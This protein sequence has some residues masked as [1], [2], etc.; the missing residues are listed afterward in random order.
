MS[1]WSWRTSLFKSTVSGSVGEGM[2]VLVGG[3]M[4]GCW[5]FGKADA[6]GKGM[7]DGAW[8]DGRGARDIGKTVHGVRDMALGTEGASRNW[9][10]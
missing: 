4:G 7:A 5:K 10:S 1:R 2:D 6:S 8:D 3:S 9:E